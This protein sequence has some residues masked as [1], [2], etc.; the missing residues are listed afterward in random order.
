MVLATL[1]QIP[2][3]RWPL[4]WLSRRAARVSAV[5]PLWLMTNDERV[6]VQRHV[7]VT[8]LAGDL[9][10]GR[11]TG[12]GLDGVFANHGGVVSRAAADEDD[13]VNLAQFGR[14]HVQSAELGRG[15]FVGEA[16]AHGVAH[17]G[18][19]LVDFLE[20]EVRVVA[21]RRILRVELDLA[22]FEIRAAGQRLDLECVGPQHGRYRSRSNKRRRACG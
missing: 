21:S 9:H 11:K 3:V 17:R 5:S 4:R 20:H 12:Q 8:E 10:L 14:R 6:F 19:L 2:S 13:A 15:F 18:R 7:P 22:D 16:A 1:L